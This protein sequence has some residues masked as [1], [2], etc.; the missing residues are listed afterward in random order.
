MKLKF[1][2]IRMT[3]KGSSDDTDK[4]LSVMDFGKMMDVA[5]MVAAQNEKHRKETADLL[6][7]F[8][9]VIDS[10]QALGEHCQE[11]VASGYEHV[12]LRSVNTT[13][14]QA[15]NVLS[16]V[17][18]EQMNAAG[19]PLDLAHHEVDAVSPDSSVEAD[20]VLEE[21]VRGY[22]WKGALLRRAKV[23]ISR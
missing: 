12:P 14:H 8:L 22:L 16:Q 20:T 23:L 21:K 3:D 19:H 10:L 4:M 7:R 2:E 1:W 6:L 11:L 18:V 5:G 17:G 9:D 13:L 15:L